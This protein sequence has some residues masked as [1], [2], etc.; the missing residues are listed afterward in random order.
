MK[1][2]LQEKVVERIYPHI[3]DSLY[4]RNNITKHHFKHHYQKSNYGFNFANNL[5]PLIFIS[6]FQSPLSPA[7]WVASPSLTLQL[8]K[9]IFLTC[10]FPNWT[11]AKKLWVMVGNLNM[12]LPIWSKTIIILHWLLSQFIKV[13]ILVTEWYNAQIILN[14]KWLQPFD[15]TMLLDLFCTWVNTAWYYQIVQTMRYS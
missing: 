8:L 10:I 15:K 9:A 14:V 1:Y 3:I 2:I 11:S 6:H 7:L 4:I 5:I 12:L 13:T